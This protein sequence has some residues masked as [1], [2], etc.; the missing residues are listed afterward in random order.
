VLAAGDSS[1]ADQPVQ[2]GVGQQDHQHLPA[3]R[4]TAFAQLVSQLR[5]SEL[6]SARQCLRNGSDRLVDGTLAKA[7]GVA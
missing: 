5:A 4:D 2:F 1:A 3:A 7:V 6:S